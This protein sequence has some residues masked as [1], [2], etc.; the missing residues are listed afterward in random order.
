TLEPCA[1]WGET[2]PCANA[3]VDAGI[4]RVVIGAG[5]P[6][7]R[8]NGQGI[9]RLLD[10]GVEVATRVL[11]TEAKDVG[12]G[13]LTRMTAGRP[14]VTLKLA[15]TL[16]GRIATASGDSHWITA[17]PARRMAHALRGRH[18][19]VMVG[20][21]TVL[22]DDPDLRCRIDG[23]RERPV[24]R[25]VA[26]SH[27][28][29]PLTA[30]VV[31][32]AGEAPT[33]ILHREGVDHARREAFE[34]TGVEL[35]SVAGTPLG[36]ELSDALNALG[37]AGLTRVMVEGGAQLAAAFLRDGLVDRI[38]WFHAPSIIGGDGVPAAAAFDIEEPSAA[39]RFVRRS[40]RPVGDD[41][42]TELAAGAA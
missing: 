11:E 17:E 33:W 2:P 15:S 36:L 37:E 34:A 6:D 41:V 13:F 40:I 25:I 19:A 42:L 26:D 9:G 20:V 12:A 5:D 4:A 30:R 23:Y 22:A 32:T 16:D 3:L 27:L 7:A 31:A 39:P 18:D 21:G 28:R 14:L 35:I 1:H 8:V 29:T 10:A 24:V 38:A